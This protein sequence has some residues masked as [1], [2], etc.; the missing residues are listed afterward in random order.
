MLQIINDMTSSNYDY[1]ITTNLT[2]LH[3][4]FHVNDFFFKKGVTIGFEEETVQVDENVGMKTLCVNVLRG[5]LVRYTVASVSN[6]DQT[7]FSECTIFLN[8]LYY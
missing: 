1:L 7:A 5:Q 3:S 4:S 2:T 8:D 6:Q